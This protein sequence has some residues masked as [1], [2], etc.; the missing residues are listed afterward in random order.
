MYTS[1]SETSAAL[2]RAQ[3]SLR[4]DWGGSTPLSRLMMR[5]SSERAVGLHIHRLGPGLSEN[6]TSFSNIIAT[7]CRSASAMR[8]KLSILATQE[9]AAGALIDRQRSAGFFEIRRMNGYGMAAFGG[10]SPRHHDRHV[11]TAEVGVLLAG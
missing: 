8:Q 9:R 6:E 7:E 4:D 3:L 2:A 11:L 1:T 5:L 10:H